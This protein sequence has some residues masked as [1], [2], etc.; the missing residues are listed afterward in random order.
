L[1]PVGKAF[2]MEAMEKTLRIVRWTARQGSWCEPMVEVWL[3]LWNPA[4]P[5]ASR[6]LSAVDATCYAT[7]FRGTCLAWNKVVAEVNPHILAKE[8]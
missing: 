1:P 4:H 3:P 8:M 7:Q 5:V 6:H 2:I